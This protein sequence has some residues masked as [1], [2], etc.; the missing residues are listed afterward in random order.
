MG[1]RRYRRGRRPSR[2]ARM[3]YKLRMRE[4]QVAE[5]FSNLD[6]VDNS[7]TIHNLTAI[8]E[9]TDSGQREGEVISIHSIDIG[10]RLRP[11]DVNST[12]S[13]VFDGYNLLYQANCHVCIM[14]VR[15]KYNEDF[16]TNPITKSQLY[17]VSRIK[18][19]FRNLN[20]L[21]DVQ[22]L[23][24]KNIYMA[25][26]DIQAQNGSTGLTTPCIA[27]YKDVAMWIR[28]RKAK[29]LRVKYDN[30]NS[31]YGS[32]FLIAYCN[33]AYASSGRKVSMYWDARVR[34]MG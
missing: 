18:N 6:L 34:F 10:M 11:C 4:L 3:L 23:W 24:R 14:L 15:A 9:G 31:K 19:Q 13:P 2:L 5:F 8:P 22:I 20:S 1:Y 29:H 7:L 30:A 25:P 27:Q 21:Q 17:D 33:N 28:P 12:T 26:T 16:V 32:I